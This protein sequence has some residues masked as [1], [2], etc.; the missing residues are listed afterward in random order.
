MKNSSISPVLTAVAL[1]GVL[2]LVPIHPADAGRLGVTT[3]TTGTNKPTP[4]P[5][6]AIR[7]HRRG[8]IVRDHRG[9]TGRPT[10]P[11]D[12]THICAGWAC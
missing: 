10:P 6:G 9:V 1:A 8:T 11:R 2:L 7:D 4:S 3:T 12:H 5:T